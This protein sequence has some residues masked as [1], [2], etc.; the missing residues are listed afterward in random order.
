TGL[1]GGEIRRVDLARAFAEAPDLILLDE[2]TNH[3]DIFA[4]QTL[5]AELQAFRGAALIVSHD[6]AF[7]E[8]VTRRCYWLEGRR[9][10]TLDKGFAAF[11]AWAAKVTEEEAESLR[12]LSKAIE[13]ETE[14]FYRSITARRSRN[15]GRARQLQQMRQLRAERAA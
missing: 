4:I 8:R 6:R 3:L 13:R 12:R 11:D 2:P 10:R 7:L 15:E 1:S 5:E 9:V 14:T